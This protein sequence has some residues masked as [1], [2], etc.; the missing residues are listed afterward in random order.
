MEK[1]MEV[2]PHSCGTEVVKAGNKLNIYKWTG[3]QPWNNAMPTAKDNLGADNLVYQ[4]PEVVFCSQMVVSKVQAM[5]VRGR[6]TKAI[7]L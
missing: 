6:S 7:L 2:R 4:V 1:E 3:L 5:K